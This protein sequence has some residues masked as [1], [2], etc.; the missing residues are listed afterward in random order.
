MT[1]NQLL[2]QHI[3]HKE[4]SLFGRYITN[5]MIA[6]I[7]DR[8]GDDFVVS[9]IGKSVEERP[10]YSVKIGT[11]KL[12]VLLWSQM[13]GN[14]S[15]TTK[16]IFDVFN[17]VKAEK[18][19][20]KGI[21]EQCTLLFVPILSPDGAERYTR[22]NANLED[23]NRD[24]Q[25]LTQ[26]E[27]RVLKSCFES[28]KPDFCFN[29]H[30]QRTIFGAGQLGNSATLSF[31]SPAEDEIRSITDT[32]KKAMSII[33]YINKHLQNDL[34]NGIGRYDDGFNINCVGDTFQSL[35][36]PT[37][38]FEAGHYL[39]DYNREQT[40]LYIYKSLYHALSYISNG[41]EVND[42]VPYFDIPENEKNFYDVIIRNAI[43]GL[44]N[45]PVDIAIQFSEVLI[46]NTIEFIPKV[47]KIE[48]LDS[49]FGHK[50][51]NADGNSVLDQN[52]NPLSI[53]SE[54]VFVM[55]NN[56]KI[57]IKPLKT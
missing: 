38:L 29:L 22:L 40:R 28:F 32:R 21:L 53:G 23:L 55:L 16:A 47:E 20:Y 18:S 51:I 46:S 25:A 45:G 4:N 14:E 49:Y 27:S 33:A 7:L 50:E 15:T 52:G 43:T 30:G 19:I 57:S 35:G 54:I 24:A 17:T 41:V 44:E 10:I 8:L 2:N 12:K 6:P 39:N 31:L 13:H 34:E 26:P 37:V 48:N 3:S 42:H 36:V 9:T 1:E 56:S 5:G 11:G